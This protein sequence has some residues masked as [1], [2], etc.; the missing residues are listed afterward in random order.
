M[1]K[2]KYYQLCP[3]NKVD[4]SARKNLY[5]DYSLLTSIFLFIW[6][7]SVPFASLRTNKI[8]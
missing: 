1:E 2:D 6:D 5:K 8:S 3:C 7:I 4:G